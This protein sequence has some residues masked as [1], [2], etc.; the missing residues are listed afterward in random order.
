MDFKLR[1]RGWASRASIVALAL[2]VF[3]LVL[4]CGAGSPEN[5]IDLLLAPAD[6]PDTQATVV[7]LAEEQSLDGRSAQ[8]ELQAPGYRVLQSLVLFDTREASLA[9]LDGIR[10]DLVSRGAAGP[11]GAE[12]SGVFEHML[13]PDEA[14]SVFFIEGA[15]LVR[16]TVTGPERRGRLESLTE[17]ARRKLGDG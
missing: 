11:G 5:P 8:V 6:F 7:S 1:M 10:A 2:L 14:A 12:A 16:L 9:A 4:A 13:G 3:P 17:V 15:A